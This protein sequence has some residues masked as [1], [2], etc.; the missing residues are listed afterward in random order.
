[1]KLVFLNIFATVKYISVMSVYFA[2]MVLYNSFDS[3]KKLSM[4]PE[5]AS[6]EEPVHTVFVTSFVIGPEQVIQISF[7][8]HPGSKGVCVSPRRTYSVPTL[9]PNV[10]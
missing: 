2:H 1:M 8:I 3:V 5:R 6:S 9:S 4:P 10:S 7:S